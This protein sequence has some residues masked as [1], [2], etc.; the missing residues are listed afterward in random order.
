HWLSEN[1]GL[2]VGLGWAFEAKTFGT[3]AGVKFG[4]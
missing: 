3:S 1:F 2:H 4:F